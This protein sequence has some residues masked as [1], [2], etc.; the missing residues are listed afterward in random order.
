VPQWLAYA[1]VDY[2]RMKPSC[3]GEEWRKLL[4]KCRPTVELWAQSA[5][6]LLPHCGQSCA[7]AE[8]SLPVPRDSATLTPIPANPF[9]LR[10]NPCP[11]AYRS[12]V[13]VLTVGHWS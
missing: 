5:L 4:A 9:W 10:L 12:K 8:L 13:Q 2:M 7:C 6:P 11:S 3:W 1:L